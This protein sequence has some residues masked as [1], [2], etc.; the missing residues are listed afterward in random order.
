M[1][2]AMSLTRSA[3]RS[4]AHGLFWFVSTIATVAHADACLD[5][6]DEAR[7]LLGKKR[8]LEAR[9]Q[10]RVCAASSCDESVRAVCEERLV[11]VTARLPS[12]IFDAKDGAGGD[13]ADVV[14]TIDGTKQE[15][16]VVGAEITLDPGP[17][18]F[19]FEAAGE[20]PRE[21]RLVLIEREKGRREHVVV[22]EP[23]LAIVPKEAPPASPPAD[24]A[25]TPSSSRPL[26]TA[27]WVTLGA[28]AVGLGIGTAFGIT[29]IVKNDDA[30]CDAQNV[31]DDPRSRHDARIA[32]GVST[33]A[34]ITGAALV[35][36]GA[37]L[38]WWGH[39]AATTR[40]VTRSLRRGVTW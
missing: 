18:V 17:H 40:T 39:G 21:L 11:E 2:Q 4:L 29:A 12:V 31:C 27:G 35:V 37:T 10:L 20:A 5:A 9:A 16:A 22:G 6:S 36:A 3:A 19:V 24:V 14:M 38:V 23:P 8:L 25:P 28:G 13:R 34:F 26:A 7:A 15:S 1:A 32:A 30:G 33:A